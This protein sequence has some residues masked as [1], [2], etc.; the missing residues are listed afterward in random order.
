MRL[1]AEFRLPL[2]TVIDTPGAALSVEAE[3]GGLAGEIARCLSDLVTLEAPTL[4]L[5]LGQGTGG[6]ALALLP[7]D[8]VV[9]AEHSWLSPLPPEGASAIVHRTTDLAPRMAE[10]Q[11]VR[12]AD[13]VADG[14]V[15]RV[16]AERP[17]AA[18][19]PEEFCT[20]MGQV[21]CEELAALLREDPDKLRSRRQERYRRLGL[22]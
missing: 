5:L 19:E 1:A 14:V 7:A 15:D 6:G 18:D 4:T 8:R 3:E 13:L 12:S 10:E 9:A 17:D 22:A 11:R 21:L 20:R 16:V 2:V